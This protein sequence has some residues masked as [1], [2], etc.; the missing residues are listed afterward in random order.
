MNEDIVLRR[1]LFDNDND[2]E[3][4]VELQN[5]VYEERGLKFNAE[6]FKK[7]Y[8]ENPV[9]RVISFNAYD[10]DKMVAHYACIPTRMK[11][12]D[13]V[14][15]GIKSMATV[16][17]PGY[18]GRGLFKRLADMTYSC[19]SKSGYEFVVGVA[20]ANSFPGFIK[21]FP[22][23]FVCQ[24]DVKI[25]FGNRIDSSEAKQFEGY[26]DAETLQWRLSCASARY[27]KHDTYITGFRGKWISTFMSNFNVSILR[28]IKCTYKKT[29]F[30]PLLYVGVGDKSKFPFVNVPKFIKRSPFNLIF[31]DLT[32]KLPEINKDNVRFN[33]IDFDVA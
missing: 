5:K 23:K 2:F 26:W 16:T 31:L 15:A 22:F 3:Q 4:L 20:N 19:A 13:R 25:G 7:W 21:Y 10:G 33:L 6:R 11:I 30:K 9:G 28:E 8:I 32:G 27:E 29:Q 18:R 17:H 1:C 14:V 12:D 24:L